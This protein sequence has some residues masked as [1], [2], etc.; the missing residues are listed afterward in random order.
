MLRKNV[1]AISV[2][3]GIPAELDE[4]AVDRPTIP[5]NPKKKPGGSNIPRL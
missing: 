4:T 2:V 5:A 3:I 1:I